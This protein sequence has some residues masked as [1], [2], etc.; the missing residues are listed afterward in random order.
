MTATPLSR[1]ARLMQAMTAE[2]LKRNPDAGPIVDRPIKEKRHHYTVTG[3][4]NREN[5][6]V[7]YWTVAPSPARAREIVASRVPECDDVSG[8][9]FA[10]WLGYE[11]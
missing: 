4:C 7:A 1:G 3:I 10:G 8:P 11:E 9:V 6:G 2:V 5:G